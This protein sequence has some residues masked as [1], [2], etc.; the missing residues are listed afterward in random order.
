MKPKSLR[1]WIVLAIGALSLAVDGRAGNTEPSG[2]PHQPKSGEFVFNFL[3]KAFQKTPDLEMTVN[4]DVTPYGRLLRTPTPD[5]PMYYITYRVGYKPMGDNVAGDS[6]PAP[7][8]LE[9]AMKKALAQSGFLPAV[10]PDHPANLV[11]FYYWGSHYRLD[12][13]TAANFP[14]LAQRHQMERAILVGGKQQLEKMARAMEWGEA[15]TDRTAEYE[16]LRD[17]A[18][19]D[20]YYV[21]ASAYDYAA[22]AKKERKLIWRTTMTVS[23]RGVAM[24]ETLVPLIATAG[25]YFGRDMQDPAIEM[26]RIDRSGNVIVGEP[27]VVSDGATP[28]K[29][30]P[31]PAPKQ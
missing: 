7:E 28:P 17:Q 27:T 23:A 24:D 30:A 10:A 12:R 29:P 18:M 20:L 2:R 26:K 13:E 19:D 9:R 22:L 31:K 1:Q 15:I 25:P 8:V 6:P 4:T 3:P 16:Y 21:V 14:Q 5:N 11:I